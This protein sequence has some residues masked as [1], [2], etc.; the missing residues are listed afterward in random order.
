MQ[1]VLNTQANYN[2]DVICDLRDSTQ[3]VEDKL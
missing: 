1:Q 3:L 2:V